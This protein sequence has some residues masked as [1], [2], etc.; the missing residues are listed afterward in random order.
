MTGCA[1][2]MLKKAMVALGKKPTQI[3]SIPPYTYKPLD[4]SADSIRL[5]VLD[6]ISRP[7][8][9]SSG[10]I[11][12]RLIT[13]K[14]A[15]K[16]KYEALS[17]TWGSPNNL[18]TI[19][20]DGHKM[21]VRENLLWALQSLCG[22]NGRVL[23]VDAICINQ[24]DLEERNQ[25][26]SLMAF[27]YRRAQAV[28][29]WLGHLNATRKYF[30][31]SD[32]DAVRKVLCCHDYWSR[33][34]IVQE[35]ALAKKIW[36]V[37][38]SIPGCGHTCQNWADFM[39]DLRS[40]NGSEGALP[41]KLEKQRDGR[42]GDTCRLEVLL[43]N[44]S[45]A[46]CK[47]PRD[48]IYGFLGLA[49][50]CQN[51]SLPVDYSKSLLDLYSDVVRFHQSAKPMTD[52]LSGKVDRA[53]RLVAFSQVVQRLFDGR[54]EAEFK[55]YDEEHDTG[56]P[57]MARGLVESAIV[58]LG[59]SYD[60]VVS[61][62][63]ETKKWKAS[64]DKWYDTSED[65][66]FLRFMDEVYTSAL[67]EM[68]PKVLAKICQTSSFRTSVGDNDA[69]GSCDI[70]NVPILGENE[71]C[72]VSTDFETW[73]QQRLERKESRSYSWPPIISDNPQ[74]SLKSTPRRFLG[75]NRTM[76][77]VPPEAQE[78]DL[79]CRF[80]G[81][82]VAAVL[83]WD[84]YRGLFHI[85]GRAHVATQWQETEGQPFS[86]NMRDGC[87]FEGAGVVDISLDIKTLQELTA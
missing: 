40:W 43:A 64:F 62:F 41:F 84:P 79:I 82:D 32:K 3:N 74:R 10:H 39:D 26:V 37:Y 30:K 45:N 50:D 33:V 4:R 21:I 27:I 22:V 69:T 86:I 5:L 51:D 59:P 52:P 85:V 53:M 70:W 25:Q 47:E 34:W 42:Y 24:D 12:C 46:Q 66:S 68:D 38:E 44:F 72:G 13:T 16:P 63:Q 76:G 2:N 36:C 18:G 48:K 49:H 11:T 60:D 23:W 61:S 83:R 57:L 78:E 20:V 7:T 71:T 67:L 29:I 75:T 8:P 19:L 31:L 9:S 77:L 56:C 14:F 65:L 1:S 81:C 6:K 87:H 54:I 58:H 28:L 73:K 80:W 35:I 15:D 17:Y 55:N